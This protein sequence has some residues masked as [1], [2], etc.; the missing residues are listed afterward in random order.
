MDM[1]TGLLLKYRGISGVQRR[2]GIDVCE[3]TLGSTGETGKA[4]NSG[5][6]CASEVSDGGHRLRSVRGR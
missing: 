3:R 6:G 1:S 2:R 5:T 4:A